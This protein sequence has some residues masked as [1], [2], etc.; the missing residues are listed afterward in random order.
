MPTIPEILMGELQIN[1]WNPIRTGF[2][3][4]RDTHVSITHLATRIYVEAS[5]EHS[6]HQ[7]RAVAMEKFEKAWS[8][9]WGKQPNDMPTAQELEALADGNDGMLL[10]EDFIAK[11]NNLAKQLRA[12]SVE[13]PNAWQ[14]AIDDELVNAHLGIAKDVITREEA[15]AELNKLIAWH[16]DA[17][18]YF[19][20]QAQQTCTACKGSGYGQPSTDSFLCPT[21]NGTGC[22]PAPA[23]G[24]NHG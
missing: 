10:D 12:A 4:R 9:Y 17:A 7:A 24:D 6:V 16:I 13:Q 22:T 18:K 15:K 5:D 23:G 3:V 20:S 11:L 1:S 8:E 14:Q 21:C 19:E 2:V